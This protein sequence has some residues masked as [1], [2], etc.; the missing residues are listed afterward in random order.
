MKTTSLQAITFTNTMGIADEF[1]KLDSFAMLLNG[2]KAE[3]QTIFGN[4]NL[5]NFLQL[6]GT[7][8]VKETIVDLYLSEKKI[9]MP[10]LITKKAIEL[11]LYAIPDISRLAEV[12]PVIA[13][14]KAE[15]SIH[16][17]QVDI[18]QMFD[19]ELGIFPYSSQNSKTPI[20][21][22][23]KAKHTWTTENDEEV[24]HLEEV[25]AFA[26][27]LKELDKTYSNP[28]FFSILDGCKGLDSLFR[29]TDNGEVR[30]QHDILLK[31]RKR[32]KAQI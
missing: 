15:L 20:F 19:A 25:K 11:G 10:G 1:R 30:L 18:S 16:L 23:V 8:K 22:R 9:S 29:F 21:E 24:R 32:N 26:L 6:L 4:F 28:P 13:W 31:Y 7:K 17:T 5:N 27:K 12:I 14:R 2:A 3:Y